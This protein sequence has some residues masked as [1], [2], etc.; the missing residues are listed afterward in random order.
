VPDPN[1]EAARAACAAAGVTDPAL[2]DACTL[3]VALS[4]DRD[5][6]IAAAVAQS[7]TAAPR[8]AVLAAAGAGQPWQDA[9]GATGTS[10]LTY[11][12]LGCTGIDAQN[13]CTGGTWTT[14][15]DAPWIW[16][17]R[18]STPGQYRVTFTAT[19]TVAAARTARL[20]ALADD[21]VAA[22]VNGEPVLTAGYNAPASIVV[23]LK[24]G[25]NTLSF[26]VANNPGDDQQGNPGG[27]AWKLV[28]E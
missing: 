1:R 28:A 18:L 19:V 8:P 14:M 15:E 27:L 5:A 3:D 21:T 4:G 11:G 17:A 26:D 24:A 20:W 16:T 23:N 2:L 9:A 22:S 6:A 12:Q 25:V 10:E 13:R 7:A